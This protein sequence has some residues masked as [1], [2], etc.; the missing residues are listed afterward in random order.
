MSDNETNQLLRE[1]RDLLASREATYDQHLAKIQKEYDRQVE[2]NAKERQK[3]VRTIT[4]MILLL[5]GLVAFAVY[6]LK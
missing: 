3:S 4:A 1:I 6:V 5:T 2:T